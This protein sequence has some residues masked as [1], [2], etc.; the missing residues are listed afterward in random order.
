MALYEELLPELYRFGICTRSD[1]QRLLKK[2]RRAL[3]TDDRSPLKLYEQ[4]HF[5]SVFGEDFVRDAV[6]RQYWFAYPA[7][8][9]NALE[10][11]FGETAAVWAEDSE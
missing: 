9:R 1:L 6:R 7:L 3:L 4:R 11:E 5:A 2:H 8:V 10:S